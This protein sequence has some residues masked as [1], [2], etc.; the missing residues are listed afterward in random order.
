MIKRQN[1][2]EMKKYA[3]FSLLIITAA[4]GLAIFHADIWQLAG[5]T[6]L[7]CVLIWNIYAYVFGMG[8]LRP[9][10]MS[11]DVSAGADKSARYFLF[12]VSVLGY[13]LLNVGLVLKHFRDSI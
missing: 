13:L 12:V 3:I 5:F 4:L 10:K 1:E 6:F 11:A 9:P 8:M 2:K 7:S